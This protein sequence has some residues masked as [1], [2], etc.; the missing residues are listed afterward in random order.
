MALQSCILFIF[1]LLFKFS[2]TCCYARSLTEPLKG[3]FSVELIHR[4][5][6]KSPF[7]NPTKTLFQ[8]LNTSFHRSLD[9]VNHF[10]AKPKATKNTPQSVIIS[11]QG[12][13]LVK[14]SIGTPPFEVMGIADTGSDLI[15]SQCKPC[16]QCY[17][18]T[19][20]LFDPSK[21]KTYE[22]VSCYSTVCQTLGQTYCL[23]DAQPNCQYTVSYGDGSHSQGN[24]AFDTL[25]L[26]STTDSPVAFP[27]IPIGCGVN[28]AGTFDT[29][30]SG[31]VG[32]G[33]GHVSLVSQIGPSIDFKFSY[34]LVPLFHPKS[35]SKLNFGENA[36]VDGPGTVSTPIIPGSVD[37]FYYLKLEGMSVGS[38]RIEFVD[39]SASNDENGN[40]IIDSGTT[41][42]ILPEKFYAKLES[43]VAANINLERVN[44]TDQIL[45]LCYNSRGHNAVKA[46]P[47]V[48]HFSGADVV[49]DSLNT[50]VSVSD[51]VLCFAFAPVE[52]GSIFGNLAQ[53]NY[54]VGYDLLRK[55]VSF[56]PTDCTKI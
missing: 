10:Y 43:E 34:C 38:K 25:T 20:P 36:V 29:E 35:S 3:G 4:D 22:P 40:I 48:A 46:P 44:I 15:W 1:F 32:L 13:Y 2:T 18:Q 31:I 47:I 7:Y 49:L 45:S 9:R 27:S 14:Y 50:F 28:N 56:K 37:T 26:G 17:N 16:E 51:D 8:K 6:P 41:L 11:N 52:S 53:M 54:L 39:D 21:S 24:L 23:S 33:G 55:T 5:S 42:T 30:G 19:S 12:E